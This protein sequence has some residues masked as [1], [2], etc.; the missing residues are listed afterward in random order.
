MIPKLF[1]REEIRSSY[2][3]ALNPSDL[4]ATTGQVE[5]EKEQLSD[6]DTVSQQN[7]Y[8]SIL[9]RHKLFQIKCLR[10]NTLFC[11]YSY[12]ACFVDAKIGDLWDIGYPQLEQ[13]RDCWFLSIC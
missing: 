7:R 3:F 1:E 11:S 13:N 2:T 12:W 9:A 8:N 4:P 10:S 5:I 6:T